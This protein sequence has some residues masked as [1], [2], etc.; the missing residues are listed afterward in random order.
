MARV[1]QERVANNCRFAS[2]S[3]I[4]FLHTLHRRFNKAAH[5]I[6]ERQAATVVTDAFKIEAKDICEDQV[7]DS[8]CNYIVNASNYI[9]SCILDAFTTG[10]HDFAPAHR[11]A[12]LN[13]CYKTTNQLRQSTDADDVAFANAIQEENGLGEFSCPERCTDSTCTHLGCVCLQAWLL[14]STL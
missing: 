4:S 12:F 11:E 6:Q 7:L 1:I 13:E 3:R 2:E 14:W 8:G 5:G 9:E 10:S